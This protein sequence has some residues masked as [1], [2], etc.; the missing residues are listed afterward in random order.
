MNSFL[1]GLLAG[2]GIAIPVGAIAV[3]IINIAL[4]QGFKAGFLA[5]AGAATADLIYASLAAVAG[6]LIAGVIFPYAQPLQTLSGVVLVLMGGWGL[7]KLRS[8]SASSPAETQNNSSRHLY[9]QFLGL[10]ILNPLTVVYFA[11]LVLG[12]S[13]GTL[14]T[15]EGKVLFVLG[16]ALASFSWQSLLAAFGALAHRH[17]PPRL[18][19]VTSV[20]GNL[21]VL[22]FGARILLQKI[23]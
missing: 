22:S 5:G 14:A 9:F 17:F 15:I 23:L 8:G 12:G 3:L 21:I 10:T 6:Q 20:L 4:R 7:W 1:A 19:V 11:A 16:A 2:F 18:Q 13:V